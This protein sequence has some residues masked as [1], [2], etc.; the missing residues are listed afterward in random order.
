MYKLNQNPL[1]FY[2]IYFE[3]PKTMLLNDLIL[4]NYTPNPGDNTSTTIMKIQKNTTQ[5]SDYDDANEIYHEFFSSNE[6][7]KDILPIELKGGSGGISSTNS[8]G[9]LY[10]ILFYVD[11]NN[12]IENGIKPISF[13][14]TSTILINQPQPETEPEPQP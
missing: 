7:G 9:T 11:K 12:N 8:N 4:T 14:L 5:V 2:H 3:V 13:T 6:I 1:G 10:A